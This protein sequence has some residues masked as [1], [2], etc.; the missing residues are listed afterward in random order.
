VTVRIALAAVI[1]A[2]LASVVATIW[3]GGRV[4]EDTVVA[5]PYE[6]GLRH[7]QDRG[8]LEACDLAAGPCTRA[9]PG[10]GDVTV[11]LAPRPLR[12]MQE[13]ALRVELGPGASGVAPAGGDV[14]VS[15][16]MP[17]MEMGENRARV[18]ATGPGRWEGKAVLV[19]CPSGRRGWVAD[20]RVARPGASPDVARFSLTVPE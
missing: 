20:V 12:T 8:R 17:G 9:L 5:R 14:S 10:G 13:L 11:D 7:G 3:I 6:E 15:F 16:S 2:A 1:A 19:P 18:A 4:R